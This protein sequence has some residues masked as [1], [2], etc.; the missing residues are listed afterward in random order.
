MDRE[1]LFEKLKAYAASDM[2]PMHMPGHKR[3][4][5]TP[6][7]RELGAAFDLTEIEGFDDLH[8]PEGVLREAQERAAALW[9]AEES[10]FLVNGSTGG[11]LAGLYAAADRGGEILLARGAHKSVYHGIELLGL[12]PRFLCPPLAPGGSFF[13]S[14]TPEAVQAALER[15]PAVRAVALTSPTYEG[16]LSDAAGIAKVC[17]E[18]GV[19]LLVDEAHG[20]HLGFGGFPGGA[21]RAGADLVIQSLHKTLPSLTQT[22]ILHRSGTLIDP[23]RLRHALSIF[24]T[25]SPSYLFLA[26]IDGCIELLRERP[27]IIARWRENLER[28]DREVSGLERIDLPLRGKLPENVFAYD[29]GK[30]LIT[31]KNG[32]SGFA[33]ADALRR[34]HH[35][36]LEMAAPDHALAMTGPGDTP[37]TLSRLAAALK[38]L[39][40]SLPDKEEAA[41]PPLPYGLLP[42]LAELPGNAMSLP[43]ELV[44]PAEAAGRTAAEYVWAY[45]P[46]VPLVIPGERLTK[47]LAEALADPRSRLRSTRGRLPEKTAV[48]RESAS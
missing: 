19:P 14:V 32:A 47:E 20:A 44:P 35:I 3:N 8:H 25:S 10:C 18:R 5:M 42:E 17:H 12:V 23:A 38:E 36:E 45:P 15:Y 13:A 26:S 46:G 6:C 16:V 29:P 30:I 37:E 4:A 21:V 48:L 9:G 24:Q 31:A 28:F 27:E 39:D 33:L 2:L 7:L 1:N 40:R 22:A 34:R 43:W 11:I 41:P